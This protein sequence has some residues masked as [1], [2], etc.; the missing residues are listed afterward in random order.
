M[1]EARDNKILTFVVARITVEMVNVDASVAWCTPTQ[2]FRA[3]VP[4]A[5]MRP[6]A[7]SIV[8]YSAMLGNKLTEW[9]VKA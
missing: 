8:E 3:P 4:V 2:Y 5:L 9:V 7:D 6:F 1:S